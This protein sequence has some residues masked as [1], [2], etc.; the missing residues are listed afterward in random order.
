MSV[1]AIGSSFALSAQSLV[2]MRRQLDDLQRQLGTGQKSESYAGVGVDRG[3][4]VG[5]RAR[6][7][8]IG[9]YED[10]MTSVSVRL[11]LAQTA[12]NRIGDVE[13]DVQTAV[14]RSNFD[15]DNTGQTTAQRNARFQL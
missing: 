4:A 11:E 12:L 1:S 5:L 2:D 3:M 10:T 15:L 6:L 8:A 13:T 14:R 7:A 9:S